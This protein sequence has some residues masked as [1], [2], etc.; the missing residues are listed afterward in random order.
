MTKKYLKWINDYDVIK[1]MDL[2]SKKHT[3][4]DVVKFIKEK[5][6]SKTEFL[7]GIY[8]KNGRKNEHIGNIKLG[9][10]NFVHRFG[11]I[12]YFI[13]NKDYWTKGYATKAVSE[14]IKIAKNKFKLK[15]LQAN[16][17]VLSPASKQILKKNNFKQE[18]VLK[19]QMI[20]QGKRY[21]SC[22]YGLI[23]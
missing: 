14:I 3:M 23:L 18:G 7:Y 9:P 13:G 1:Y 2:W 8:L 21:N 17:I 16:V 15:K 19:S 10:I 11:S 4:N 20:F 6:K 12:S 5:Q 22:L